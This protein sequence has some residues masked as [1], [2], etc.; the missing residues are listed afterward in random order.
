MC[1][2]PRGTILPADARVIEIEHLRR[3]G[4]PGEGKVCP[5]GCVG[6]LVWRP[7]EFANPRRPVK[8]LASPCS[9][10]EE[11]REP[12]DPEL[13]TGGGEAEMV[14]RDEARQLLAALQRLSLEHRAV[15]SLFALEGVPHRE[16]AEVL[17]V[18]EGTI[19]SR[20][21]AARKRLA[22]EVGRGQS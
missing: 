7:C 15:L 12:L 4:L 21:H 2:D 19:W 11:R 10:G 16:I 8:V 22:E 13:P 6:T 9:K 14:S 20:L 3:E 18:A 17:G 1:G 5:H